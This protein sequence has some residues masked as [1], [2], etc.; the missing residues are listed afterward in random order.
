MRLTAFALALSL[1]STAL[2]DIAPMR[3]VGGTSIR[4]MKPTETRV[5]M[6]HEVI[7]LRLSPDH[8]EVNVVFR[9]KNHGDKAETIAVG[10]PSNYKGELLDFKAQVKGEA[11][12]VVDKMTSQDYDRGE[13]VQT[14]FTYWK[15]WEMTFPAGTE[16]TVEVDYATDFKFEPWRTSGSLHQEFE[17]RN[18][19][20]L[21]LSADEWKSFR[22]KFRFRDF[23]Y[24]LRTGSQWHKRISKCRVELALTRL[25]SDQVS[26]R[27][28]TRPTF[29]KVLPN[30][31][32]WEW[33]NLEPKS[34]L[35]FHTTPGSTAAEREATFAELYK[36]FPES[37]LI[38]TNYSNYLI[39]RDAPKDA[40]RV[41]RDHLKHWVDKIS[42]WGPEDIS[43][44]ELIQSRAVWQLA[45]D[46]SVGSLRI[47]Y[48]GHTKASKSSEP[49]IIAPLIRM[50]A[51]RVES[52][53]KFAPEDSRSAKFY[54]GQVV[55]LKEWADKQILT[56]PK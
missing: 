37:P 31:M 26:L 55:E 34:D 47:P 19:P 44:G 43:Q 20:G 18:V 4:P 13:F 23:H 7:R 42:F 28:P 52:Q 41:Y 10:F 6:D 32:I 56:K 9:M 53:L 39:K 21:K 17:D 49:E 54:A 29:S 25:R 27:Y 1:A 2:A 24:V 35:Q 33:R 22:E 8:C 5:A 48:A 51:E 16:T 30:S 50:L 46:L 40:A 12:K 45:V 38:A 14:R 36:K 3:L 11:V 15:A